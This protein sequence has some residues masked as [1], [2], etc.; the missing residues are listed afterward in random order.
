MPHIPAVD[1]GDLLYGDA[2]LVI[3]T[4]ELDALEGYSDE[5]RDE[6][7]TWQLETGLNSVSLWARWDDAEVPIYSMAPNGSWFSLSVAVHENVTDAHVSDA[8]VTVVAEPWDVSEDDWQAMETAEKIIA[9]QLLPHIHDGTAIPEM[10]EVVKWCEQRQPE[11]ES[12]NE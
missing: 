4:S 7:R 5:E 3:Y 2:E 9:N 11:G 6:M 1:D 12:E 10:V 8:F